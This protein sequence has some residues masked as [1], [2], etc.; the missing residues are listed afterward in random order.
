MSEHKYRIVGVAMQD[1]SR[2]GA[3]IGEAD[4][5]AEVRA[6][7]VEQLRPGEAVNVIGRRHGR[8]VARFQRCEGASV[9]R[10]PLHTGLQ[11][12]GR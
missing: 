10:W 11:G 5:L 6:F 12:Q 2:V 7:C 8:L 1:E 9:R 3:D 4:S